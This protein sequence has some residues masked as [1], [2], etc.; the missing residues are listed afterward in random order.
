M[1]A[2]E[3][4][5]LGLAV[6]YHG[7][8]YL[9]TLISEGD[10]QKM[11]GPHGGM[12]LL[13]IAVVALW[14]NKVSGDKARAKAIAIQDEK[15]DKRRLEEEANKEKRHAETLAASH[16]YAYQMKA[17]A[18]ESMKVTMKVD[19]T[20][21]ELTKE[22]SSRPCQAA[23]FLPVPPIPSPTPPHPSSPHPAE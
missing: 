19:H 6:G 2:I 16:E 13:A 10:W 17:L 1:H 21:A 23:K 14:L 8:R 7:A 20:L 3:A 22:L 12:F 18:V 15:E 11:T 5:L 9:G 4:I